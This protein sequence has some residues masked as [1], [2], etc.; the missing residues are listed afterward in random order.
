MYK[1]SQMDYD[2]TKPA[3]GTIL[4]QTGT[5]FTELPIFMT[6]IVSSEMNVGWDDDSVI[7]LQIE[8]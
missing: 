2:W 7:F 8:D 6:E 1:K 4:F 3:M 5:Y